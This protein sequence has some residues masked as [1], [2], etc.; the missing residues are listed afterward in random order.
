MFSILLFGSCSSEKTLS[1]QVKYDWDIKYNSSKDDVNERP[2][3]LNKKLKNSSVQ[4]QTERQ[5]S[6]PTVKNNQDLLAS[7]DKVD[8]QVFIKNYSYKK[9]P[10]IIQKERIY[11]SFN[12]KSQIFED[13]KI[14]NKKFKINDKTKKILKIIGAS[15]LIGFTG[16]FSLITIVYML[17]EG[18]TGGS[19]LLLLISS[20]LVFLSSFFVKKITKSNSK[21]KK[22]KKLPTLKQ[23]LLLTLTTLVCS[24]TGLVLGA[25]GLFFYG[26]F[27]ENILTPLGSISFLISIFLIYRSY[28]SV[29]KSIERNSKENNKNDVKAST[30]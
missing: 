10:K 16:F 18:L 11:K 25:Y 3:N 15:I 19:V 8:P 24:F 26:N 27:F 14:I 2:Y 9:L 12:E 30:D 17:F 28:V 7:N 21:D 4:N 29:K 13:E 23:V 20:L 6:L 5:I 1:E 22:D